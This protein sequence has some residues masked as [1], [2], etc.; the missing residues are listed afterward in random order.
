MRI[1]PYI[2]YMFGLLLVISVLIRSSRERTPRQN[3]RRIIVGLLSLLIATAWWLKIGS[4]NDII[5]A[6]VAGLSAGATTV[7]ID[8]RR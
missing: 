2:P 5:G 4:V 7:A 6:M 8:R 3:R 1:L